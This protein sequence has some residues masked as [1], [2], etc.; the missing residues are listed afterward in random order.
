MATQF[1]AGLAEQMVLD[2]GDAS[3]SI[4]IGR[5]AHPVLAYVARRF[6]LYLISLW[7][8]ITASFIFFRLIPGD[9]ISAIINA[10]ASKGQYSSQSGSEDVSKYYRKA[11][12]LDG[13]LFE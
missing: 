3:E 11:F 10:L 6:G 12:G 13:N 8:A 4:A 5:K 7:G 9:P 1:P 2:A